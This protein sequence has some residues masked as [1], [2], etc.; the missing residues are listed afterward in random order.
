[1]ATEDS[2]IQ[3]LRLQLAMNAETWKALLRNGLKP[4]TELQLDFYF[5]APSEEK[6]QHLKDLLEEYDYEVEIGKVEADSESKWFVSGKTIPTTLSLE[7]L[8]QWVEWMIAAGKEYN[9]VFDGWSTSV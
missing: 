5:Y 3:N 9:S 7:I 4:D 6:A 2:Y 8:D 1:M